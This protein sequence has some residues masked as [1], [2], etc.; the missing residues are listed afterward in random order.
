M[1]RKTANS[2][3]I[4]MNIFSVI[5]DHFHPST[6]LS[7]RLQ[8]LIDTVSLTTSMSISA[9]FLGNRAEID[10][11]VV[12][13]IN[14]IGMSHFLAL[15]GFHFSLCFSMIRGIV[16]KF[17]SRRMLGI[18]LLL[19]LLWYLS[20]LPQTASI[21]RASGM[22]FISVVSR[23][24]LLR[25]YHGLLAL[26]FVL[27]G[28][29]AFAPAVF[30]SVG[31]QLSALATGSLLVLPR[32]NTTHALRALHVGDLEDR[33]IP[34]FLVSDGL[35][36]LIV[37]SYLVSIWI[38]LWITPLVLL[39]F[40]EYALWYTFLSPWYTGL[41]VVYFT[42][43]V[44]VVLGWL[45]LGV[46]LPASLLV[47]VARPL[48]FL[49]DMASEVFWRLTLETPVVPIAVSGWFVEPWHLWV[50]WVGLG[51][52]VW[53][54]HRQRRVQKQRT[55]PRYSPIRVGMRTDES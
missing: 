29:S 48:T 10:Q 45:L 37:E 18:V 2:I 11:M 19:V 52:V 14:T 21:L 38:A 41:F 36:R 46:V 7:L 20:I 30:D 31:L 15:S 26:L 51:G 43:L 40:G 49:L 33:V 1:V 35:A 9:F 50:W 44:G 16:E 12:D 8:G 6:L 32:L 22:L 4:L 54:M 25:R 28:I 5:S 53:V 34:S 13:K 42:L 24:L 47:P 17:L 39:V 27:S 55:L 3:D 23:Y